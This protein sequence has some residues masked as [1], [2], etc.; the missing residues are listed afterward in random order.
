[1]MTS[2]DLI[3]DKE[4]PDREKFKNENS[5]LFNWFCDVKLESVFMKYLNFNDL[6][7]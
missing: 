3:S 2:K 6:T 4:N 7:I 5:V 1:M